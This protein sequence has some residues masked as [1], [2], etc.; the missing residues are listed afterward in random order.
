MWFRKKQKAAPD[1]DKTGMDP[2][3]RS[4]ICTG[5]QVAGFKDS[6]TGKFHEIAL[7]RGEGDLERFL[8]EYQVKRD[9]LKKEW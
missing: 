7:I 9:E 3:L 5:E 2:V 1:F 6:K 8:E 4:S